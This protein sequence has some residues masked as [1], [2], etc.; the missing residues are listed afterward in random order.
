M[1]KYLLRGESLPSVNGVDSERAFLYAAIREKA[2]R[3]VL[4]FPDKEVRDC[5]FVTSSQKR[6]DRI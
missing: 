2:M 1:D 6:E 3:E 4:E 5:K